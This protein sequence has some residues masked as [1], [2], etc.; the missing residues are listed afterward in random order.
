MLKNINIKEVYNSEVDNILEDFYLPVLT[1]SVK[2]DRSVGY[3][4]AKVLTS[5][6]RGLASFVDNGGYIRYIIGA[7][8]KEEEYEAISLGY[9]NREIIEK[10]ES[11][12]ENEINK[13]NDDLF[14]NQLNALT[15]FIQNKRM[16]IKIAIR[17]GGIHHEKIG[18]FRD[19]NDDYIVFQGS[20]NETNNALIPFN[21]ESI[22]VF[23]GWLPQFEGHTQPHINTFEDLWNGQTKNTKVVEF[24]EIANKI[25]SRKISNPQKPISSIELN[26]WKEYFE[27]ENDSFNVLEPN[28]P[29][30]LFGNDF[31]LKK[32]QKEA[33]QK[34]QKNNYKGILELATGAGKTITSIYGA[35]KMYENRKKLLLI[36]SVP[37]QGLADQW[38]EE[39]RNFNIHSIL[40][41]GGEQNWKSNLKEKLVNFQTGLSKFLAI[42]VVDATLSSK[43]KTFSKMLESLGND[44]SSYFMFIG[45]E[46]HHHGATVI[47]QFLP[48]NAGLRMGLSATPDRGENDTEGNENLKNYYGDI[49]AS[50]TLEDALKDKVLTPYDYHL[51]NVNLTEEESENYI[52]LSKQ[53]SRAYA[54]S[55]NNKD[56]D[57][58]DEKLNILLNKRARLINGCQNKPIKLKEL[59]KSMKPIK[60]SL[61]YCAEGKIDEYQSQE[62]DEIGK[63][64]IEKI[65]KILHE[66]DWKSSRFTAVEDKKAR[67]KILENFKN[68]TID[69]LVAMKC[70]DE[71]IDVPACTTAFILASSRKPRQ[72]IQRRGRI[73]RKSKGKTKAVIYDFFVSLPVAQLEDNQ[74]ERKLLLSELGRINEFAKLSK[75][76]A[77][78]YKTIEPY[79]KKNDLM[80]YFN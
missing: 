40:C 46:C 50:Y 66:L 44:I 33:L 1:N 41:Y 65:S 21:Y 56:S 57:I 67:E 77:D 19:S 10:L 14:L 34:W 45:D 24:T 35:V 11:D 52:E 74:M 78:V 7:T 29:K 18:I 49:V 12:F 39:L 76:K 60:H 37:Y 15:W 73:L 51:I 16:D 20:A 23:K 2:Y 22:N 62:D 59:L 8:L 69:S 5:A 72:F 13:F 54:A 32:H 28:I 4:D 17:K 43:S 25:L 63:R 38:V 55:L 68:G 79:L 26:L 3:F 42:V 48:T 75:N 53:I 47:N 36:V 80:H 30:K 9:S 64:Q 58:F 6:A 61:F 31:E 27:E 70:L 71:G